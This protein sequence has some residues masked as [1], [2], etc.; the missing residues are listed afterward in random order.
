MLPDKAGQAERQNHNSQASSVI[1]AR[2]LLFSALTQD[3]RYFCGYA[4]SR[5]KNCNQRA[6]V[7]FECLH[8]SLTHLC[9][10]TTT[11]PSQPVASEA[12]PQNG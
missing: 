11:H 5:T 12:T 9:F 10:R 4:D 2:S 7:W 8:F 6:P 1:T 3:M